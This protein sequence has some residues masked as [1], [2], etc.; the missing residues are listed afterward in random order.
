MTDRTPEQWLKLLSAKL[1]D[2]AKKVDR[3]EKYNDGDH[4]LPKPPESLSA[5]VFAEACNAFRALAKM[6]VTNWVRLVAR[7]PSERLSVVGFRF[8][9]STTSARDVWDIWQ[10]NH[11]DADSRLVHD[12]SFAATTAYALVWADADGHPVITPEHPSQM[13]VAYV[14]GS[15][16]RRAAALK[17]WLDDD[18]RWL[19]TVYLPDGLYKFQSTTTKPT[20]ADVKWGEREVPGETWPLANPLGVVPVVE[21][22]CNPGLKVRPFGGGVGE[23]EPVLSIQDRINKTVF[24]RL[25]TGESQAFRQ[26]YAIGWEP[27]V[28]PVTKKVDPRQVFRASQSIL[29]TFPDDKT[30]VGEFSQADFAPFIKAVESDVNAM[31]AITQTPPTYLLGA[32]VNISGDALQAAETGMVSKTTA[33]R[34]QFSESW[35]EVLRLALRVIGD[36]RADDQQSAVMWA[37][38]ERVTW[39]QKMD[40]LTKMLGLGV[41]V[42]EVWARIPGV[43]PPDVDRW[44]AMK[45]VEPTPELTLKDKVDAATALFRA[46]YAPAA[47]LMAVGLP[48]IEH[49]GLLPVTVKASVDGTVDDPEIAPVPAPAL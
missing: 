8:G 25:A 21:F 17:R 19:A 10:R 20:G 32:M 34:D 15:R 14:A 43:G 47:A 45:S 7:A 29:W 40:A 1:D 30:K 2:Q 5:E 31:A 41:P 46:G 26:R 3:L 23:F 6:G 49:T 36:P 12:T 16:R 35:E 44:L 39:A 4:P 42:T 27:D 9:E 38:I 33:H 18:G 37:D 22:A 48:P 13:I 24:D 11:L 28:D